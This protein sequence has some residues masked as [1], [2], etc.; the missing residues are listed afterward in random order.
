[1]K[2]TE[3]Q[4]SEREQEGFLSRW[5]RRKLQ[6]AH[7]PMDASQEPQTDPQPE[8]LKETQNIAAT[9]PEASPPPSPPQT[10]PVESLTEQSRLDDFLSPQVS[11]SL[12]RRA[13]RK[14]F[15]SGKFNI[16]D[17]LD[18]Y[19]DDFTSFAPLGD[20]V[21]AEMRRMHERVKERQAREEDSAA[22]SADAKS[23]SES[24]SEIES[25]AQAQVAKEENDSAPASPVA[26][27]EADSDSHRQEY[28][29]KRPD[30]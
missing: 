29:R 14:V 3:T 13:L 27:T 19:D 25:E 30:K 8:T 4:T 18:D 16:R 22:E 7:A 23:E 15:L 12:Q 28:K 21:P 11:E 10:P 26:Q 1:M 2:K 6:S 9:D 17:G 24:K 5:S 20:V